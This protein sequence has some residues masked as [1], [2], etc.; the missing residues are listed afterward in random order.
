[1]SANDFIVFAGN[2]NIPLANKIVDSIGI[3]LGALE[4]KRFSDG[5]IW[6]KYGEN[7]RG[8]EVFL[9]Q[10]TNPP[11]ENLMEL[12]IMIDAARRASAK[13][14]TAVIPYFGYARQ[15]RKD[16]PR[17]SITAKLMANLITKAGADRVMTMDLHASQIQGFFDIPVD[18]LYGS[19]IFLNY[20]SSLSD[21]LAVV[22]PD[23][24]G[25]KIARAYA[26]MLHSGLIV[27][28]KRRPKQNLA[29]VMN[30]IG[31]V[32]DKDILLVD[33]LIDTAGTFVGAAKALKEKG[34]KQIFGAV[35]HPLLSGPA[36][37]RI[38][39][40]EI[41]KLFVT[42]TIN[43]DPNKSEKIKTLTAA[44]LFAEAILRTFNNESISSLF[45]IDKG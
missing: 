29:E 25:I 20:L 43:F 39:S 5:E 37:E 28:D 21:N 24:G 23:V 3:P 42:D 16:Q 44:P 13:R 6:V 10:S 11:A 1:M 2:S 27:I 38:N 14:I 7:I 33:D 35:T 36:F 19:S 9:I 30:I 15:D 18:H 40:G 4:V 32:E 45:N 31:E 34:A 41:D 8:R 26:K 22:S 17:V 12:L